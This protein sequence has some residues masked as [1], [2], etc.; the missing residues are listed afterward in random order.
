VVGEGGL[1]GQPEDHFAVEPSL[2]ADEQGDFGGP[3]TADI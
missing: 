3:G 2:G 1:G